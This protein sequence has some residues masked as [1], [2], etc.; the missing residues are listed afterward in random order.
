M[1]RAYEKSGHP[2]WYGFFY[3]L[4]VY[5]MAMSIGTSILSIVPKRKIFFSVLGERTIYPYLL[6]AYILPGLL[7]NFGFYNF[8][9]T[10][11]DKIMVIIFAI[12]ICLAFSTQIVCKMLYPLVNVNT[13]IL[14]AKVWKNDVSR[15]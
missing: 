1:D 10:I 2:E 11:F 7:I 12:V 3:R 8:I 5:C 6:H 9:T 4:I 15:G 13:D 14:W